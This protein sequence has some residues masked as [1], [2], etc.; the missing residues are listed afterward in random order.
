VTETRIAPDGVRRRRVCTGCKRRFTT[1]EKVGSPGLKVSKRDGS[2]ELFDADKLQRALRRV[3]RHRPA[4]R[5]D[6]LRRVARDIEASLVD[7]GQRVVAWADIVRHALHRLDAIDPLSSRRMIGNYLD[8]A[9]DLR[10]DPL[11]SA[12]PPQLDLPHVQPIK[13]DDES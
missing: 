6:D 11:P 4:V 12:E 2:I 8:D 3:C 5:D 9:G 7:S 10:L 13:P 1:Y